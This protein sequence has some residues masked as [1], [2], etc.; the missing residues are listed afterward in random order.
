MKH[1]DWKKAVAFA[2]ACI[3]LITAIPSSAFA[4]TSEVEKTSTEELSTEYTYESN[5][6]V[7]YINTENGVSITSKVDYVNATMKIQGNDTYSDSS[8]LYDGA[9]EIRGR[10][11]STWSMPKKPYK[12]KLDKKTNLFNMGKNKHWVLLANYSDES[13]MRNTL[14]YNLSGAM[15]MPQ[16]ETVWVDV[17]LNGEYVGNYQFCEQIKIDDDNRV[18]IFDWESFAED[19]AEMIATTE[20]FSEDDAGDLE[21]HMKENDMSWITTGSVTF[22]NT[23][24]TISNYPDIEVPSITGGY[25]MELDEYYDEVSKFRTNSDQPIMF[26]NP[27][28]VATNQDMMN[29]MQTYIQSFENAVQSYDYTAEYNG[30]ATHYSQ[31]FDF[32]SLVD[33]WLI[34]EIFFNEELNKKSTYMYKDIDGLVYMGPI[35]D[36]DYSSGGE[37]QTWLTNEWA[38]VFYNTNAQKNMW[39]KDLIK[40][41]YFILKAQERYW[42]IRDTYVQAMLDSINTNYTLLKDSADANADIWYDYRNFDSE[43]NN[44][45]TWFTNHLAWL[46]TQM[47]SEDSLLTSLNYSTSLLTLSVTDSVGN[48]LLKDNYSA[49]IAADALANIGEDIILNVS[50]DTYNKETA[51]VFVNSKKIGSVPIGSGI[52]ITADQLTA[53]SGEKNI[54]EVKV[55]TYNGLSKNC[56]TVIETDTSLLPP[57]EP[58]EPESPDTPE[59]TD[60]EFSGRDYPITSMTATAGSSNDASDVEGP[61]EYAIDGDTFTRWHTTYGQFTPLE[62][63]WIGVELAETIMVDGIRCLPRQEGVNGMVTEYAIQYRTTTEED[64]KTV[65]TGNWDETDIGWKLVSFKPVEAKYIR[66]VGV[67]TYSASATDKHM[68]MAELRVQKAADDNSAK[69]VASI[70]LTKTANKTTYITGEKFDPKGLELTVT[71]TDDTSSVI[72]YN[73]PGVTFTPSTTTALTLN[74]KLITITYAGQTTTMN[75]TVSDYPIYESN[76]PVVY[77]NTENGAKITSKVDYVNATM[78]IQGNDTYSD[79]SI[80]Y[81]G[82]IEIRGRGNTT[83]SMPKKPYKIKLDKKA[84]LFDMGKNKHWVLLANYSDESLMRN[85][86]AYNLSGAMGMPQME[87]VWVDVVLNGE[88]VGNYQFCEQIKVDKN[89]RVS[90]FDWESF[91]EDAAEVIATS[92]NFSDDDA[93]DLEDYMKEE[94]MSWITAGTVKFNNTTYTLSHYPDIEIP[95]ITGGYLMELDEYFDEVSKFRTNSDQPIM[96]K[97]PEFVATNQDMMNYMQTY[98]QSFENAVQSYDYTAEYNGTATHY[99]QLFDFDSLVDYWLIS[100]IFFNEELNKKSTYMY[101]DIDGLVYMGPIWDMDYSSGGEGQTWLTNE[102]ATVFYN[103]NAQKNMWYKDLIKD[104]YFILKA[105][106]RYWEIRDTYVQAMLDSINT[107][108]TLLKDSA[109]ANADIWYD[110]RNFDSE[111]NNLKTWF[112][113]H[114]AWLDT[115]MASEASLLSSLGYEATDLTLSATD[116]SGKALRQDNI[117]SQVAADALVNIGE[118]VILTVTSNNYSQEKADVF[119][120]GQKIDSVQMGSNITITAEQL[121]ANY[122]EKNIIEVKLSD[123]YKSVQNCMTVIETNDIGA[124]LAGY[125]LSLEGN[126]GVNFHMQLS[127]EVL[128]DTNAYMNFT[129]DG[130]EYMQIPITEELAKTING[131]K[132]YIFKCGVPVKDLDTEITAQIVLSDGK[133]SSE[134]HYTVRK[135]MD[136]IG[137]HTQDFE[138]EISL[139]NAMSNFGNFAS[140]YF[141]DESISEIPEEMLAITSDTLKTYQGTRPESSIYYGSSLLLKSDTILRHY[142]TEEVTGSTKKGNLYYID[143]TGIPAHELGKELKTIVDD[144]EIIYSPLSYAYIAL[145][146]ND[147]ANENLKNLM[148]AMYLYHQ[149]AL[150]YLKTTTN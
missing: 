118:S 93:G 140:A 4:Q 89:N 53:I 5:L 147:V 27:E 141:T 31:L 150:D 39:Y 126:I 23:T 127:D 78:K 1:F 97:N 52:T 99:S 19:A 149:S 131:T 144:M 33:Y 72:A 14:A 132:Y 71:Y 12:I 85:T 96:F 109:D 112:T 26:K 103:T 134:Y 57:P 48:A 87:T 101:K 110:Y 124:R 77:I 35:W 120:N 128:S 61:A 69:T 86:L 51:D 88:Y 117:S 37:G 116:S 55:S 46:D 80:L 148:R 60:P 22:K 59:T 32:D 49:Q 123:N 145:C 20:N 98:I 56:I 105:Q 45:K 106:E 15:G 130:K 44:L 138:K 24:Y 115:Q 95:S 67:H 142:F 47:A 82:E 64:W 6:P 11:N 17:V 90:I 41:P 7:I 139:V 94:D 62:Q 75:I 68:S 66:I 137:E 13:L 50:S 133:K 58:S 100:E 108:Y 3:M 34:S 136:Y 18:S 8:I 113:N 9:I 70:S 146:Q 38:T 73:A 92:E 74:D 42:E 114:L 83:W 104:P 16:M 65:A 125:T 21:D 129:L 102:W 40:D 36:M 107:N 29:Y 81:D 30:T 84:N 135:Y 91:A 54:I 119:V 43:I 10:G 25:L 122:G 2:L 63:R 121:T 76:L 111:I 79:S 28:F 143:S